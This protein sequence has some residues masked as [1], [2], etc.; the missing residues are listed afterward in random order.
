MTGCAAILPGLVTG[1][2]PMDLY[3]YP[4]NS[5]VAHFLGTTNMIKGEVVTVDGTTVLKAE[6]GL[7][8]PLDIP[9]DG[10]HGAIV[11]RPQSVHVNPETAT[12][13]AM[14]LSGTIESLEFLGS[15]VRY[16]VKVGKVT[17]LADEDHQRGKKVYDEMEQV[18][19][20]IP[21]EQIL[22]V[23]A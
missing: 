12:T 3:D 13:S 7:E 14:N 21:Q 15:T 17:V 5:F 18:Q 20:M 9:V 2:S 19:L 22:F 23:N 11:F 10:H 6:G 8:L 1:T 16:G 4:A